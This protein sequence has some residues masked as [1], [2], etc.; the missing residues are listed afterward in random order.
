MQGF[1][2]LLLAAALGINVTVLVKKLQHSHGK[3]NLAIVVVI[4]NLF[5]T[6]F[7]TPPLPLKIS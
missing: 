1:V 4:N 5:R 6:T 2:F 3:I 7:A